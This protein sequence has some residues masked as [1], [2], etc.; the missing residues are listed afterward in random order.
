MWSLSSEPGLLTLLQLPS[1]GGMV[2]AEKASECDCIRIL[3]RIL[4]TAMVLDM[5]LMEGPRLGRE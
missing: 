3:G 1:V 4:V 5:E 2:W